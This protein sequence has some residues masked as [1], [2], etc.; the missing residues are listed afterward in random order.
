MSIVSEALMHNF[1]FFVREYLL[2]QFESMA[3]AMVVTAYYPRVAF[4]VGERF[5]STG[6][7]ILKPG[8]RPE[9]PSTAVSG[10]IVP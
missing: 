9:S 8:E 6:A 2:E 3:P 4:G 10:W 5:G 1:N 7:Y